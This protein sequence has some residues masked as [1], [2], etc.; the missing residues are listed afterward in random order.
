MNPDIKKNLLSILSHCTGKRIKGGFILLAIILS[1][2]AC[3]NGVPIKQEL[4]QEIH[5]KEKSNYCYMMRLLGMRCDNDFKGIPFSCRILASPKGDS[6]YIID[7]YHYGEVELVEWRQLPVS[8]LRF[9]S[10]MN[11]E[12]K[13]IAWKT[14][15]KAIDTE[16]IGPV[17][18]QLDSL[19]FWKMS[20]PDSVLGPGF[21]PAKGR[22]ELIAACSKK[23]N[24]VVRYHLG[25]PLD[26]VYK[27]ILQLAD[28][29]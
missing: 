10:L 29:K 26:S 2:S 23:R 25:T 3:D 16:L 21:L 18:K 5:D 13:G 24:A 15:I 14:Y 11:N 1:L 27:R 8:G 7:I 19:A 22:Y 6:V 12:Y 4:K 9:D 17:K 28:I 20:C